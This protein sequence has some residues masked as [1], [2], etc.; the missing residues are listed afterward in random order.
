MPGLS[1]AEARDVDRQQESMPAAG[2]TV[3]DLERHQAVVRLRDRYATDDLSLDEFSYALDTV[4]GATTPE[5]LERAS[6]VVPRS[7]PVSLA[8]WDDA[9]RLAEHLSSDE[10]ILWVGRPGRRSLFAGRRLGGVPFLVVWFGFIIFWE[11]TA[12]GSGA[13]VFFPIFGAGML[14]AGIAQVRRAQGVGG[15]S[16]LYA[17][18]TTH[19]VR[20]I[21]GRA[22]A[23]VDR[24]LIR[25]LPNIS[26]SPT[27]GGRGTV[28]FGN[29]LQASSR[30]APFS[31]GDV[32]NSRADGV[33]EF[34]DVADASAVAR[35][36]AGL[37]S[38][39]R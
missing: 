2:A 39:A 11:V 30:G 12:I 1:A 34:L 20:L 4:L 32:S 24:A 27:S 14:L 26:V 6:P 23:R 16:A 22:G 31:L 38:H 9:G 18:T 17:V 8:P 35:L 21:E 10:E 29:S 13:P 37:Q 25:S 28:T 33:I 7:A 5:E 15:R 36:V 19:V 3:N